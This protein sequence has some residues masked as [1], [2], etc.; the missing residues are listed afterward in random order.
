MPTVELAVRVRREVQGVVEEPPVD[1]LG[2]PISRVNWS[3]ALCRLAAFIESGEPHQVIT[4]DASAVVIA[5]G[6]AEHREIWRRAD[7]VTPDGA[8]ILWAARRLGEPLR[9]RVPGVEIAEA[10]CRM[11]ADRGLGVFFYGAAPGVADAAAAAMQ[12]RYPELRVAGTEHG[13]ITPE[14]QRQL[15]GRIREARP[16]VLLV[17]LGIPRQEKWIAAHL[18]EL[19][20]PVCVG[21]G[22]TLDVFAGSVDRAPLWMQRRGLEW[23]YRLCRDPR[24]IRK[25]ATLPRFMWRVLRRQRVKVP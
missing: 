24:K 5:A 12:A 15:V 19:G 14:E 13:F 11:A 2:L 22:G 8:G 25:V 20:V 23:L 18:R 21:V 10:L 3:E 16:A 17:A 9:E 4:A 6:D 1:L 7:L